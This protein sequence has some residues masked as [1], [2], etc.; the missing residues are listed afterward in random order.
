MPAGGNFF[1]YEKVGTEHAIYEVVRS[2]SPMGSCVRKEGEEQRLIIDPS[3]LML[4][5]SQHTPPEWIDRMAVSLGVTALSLTMLCC[6]WAAP[7]NA[8]AF[9]MRDGDGEIIGIRLRAQD[10]KKWAVTGSRQGI[11]VPISPAERTVYIC[12]GPTDTAAAL[13]I[14]L[15]A[16]GRPSCTGGTD[17]L[18]VTIERLG[19]C[20]AVLASDNDKPGLK[21]AAKLAQEIGVP[22]CT[23]IPPA[24]D[25]R[26]FVN[27]GG[28]KQLIETLTRSMVW[29]IPRNRD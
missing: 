9:P 29:N 6:A 26:A 25:L 19:I 22:T 21:G 8:W 17:Q 27:N 11:F 5:W 4:E 10:G 12:E 15:F 18:K 28:T 3:G 1:P 2:Q 7:H 24:K 20:K 23:F 16:V 14:G 13:S